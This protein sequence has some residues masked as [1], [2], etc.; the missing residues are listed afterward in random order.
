MKLLEKLPL[1]TAQ[2]LL[3]EYMPDDL[4]DDYTLKELLDYD[5]RGPFADNLNDMGKAAAVTAL[6][7]IIG[8]LAIPAHYQEMP[9]EYAEEADKLTKDQTWW[10]KDRELYLRRLI[11]EEEREWD[12]CHETRGLNGSY[13]EYVD[14]HSDADPGL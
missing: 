3:W 2:W 6:S 4:D 10:T 12:E 8:K 7:R 14:E 13:D 1:R 5:P 11:E 9:P